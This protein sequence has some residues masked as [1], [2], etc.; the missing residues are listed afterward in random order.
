V[1]ST[2]LI[3]ATKKNQHPVFFTDRM[4]FLLPKQPNQQCQSTEGKLSH[5]VDLLTPSSPEIRF[6]FYK[7]I[8]DCFFLILL[9]LTNTI[10]SVL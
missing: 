8:S 2:S 10:I 3:I 6:S 5:S 4:P 9:A 7:F 1:Q